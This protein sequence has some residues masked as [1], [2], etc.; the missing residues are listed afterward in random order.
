MA[1]VISTVGVVR[2]ENAAG[3]RTGCVDI[4]LD[5]AGNTHMRVNRSG[6]EVVLVF[7]PSQSRSIAKLL[8]T[9]ADAGEQT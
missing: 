4:C 8:N 7:T 9:S 3:L 6:N 1:G 5:E 2:F